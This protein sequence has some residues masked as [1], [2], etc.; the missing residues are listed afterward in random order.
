MR[1]LNPFWFVGVLLAASLVLWAALPATEAFTGANTTDLVTHNGSWTYSNGGD[2]EIN[3]NAGRCA[4]GNYDGIAY[5]NAD[6]FDSDQYSQAVVANLSGDTWI[7]VIVR[8]NGASMNNGYYATWDASGENLVLRELTAGS[9]A[10]IATTAAAGLEVSDVVRLEAEGTYLT[11]KVNGSTVLGPS[12]DSSFA[13]GSAGIVCYAPEGSRI[14]DW[15][16]GNLAAPAGRRKI[17][18]LSFGSPLWFD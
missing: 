12:T 4:Q 13:S 5:W 10:N 18:L 1:R 14:D 2:W 3:T 9:W 11:V 16:G 6:S 7:G 15:E 8:V 17:T